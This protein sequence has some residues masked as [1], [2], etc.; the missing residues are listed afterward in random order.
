MVGVI[1]GAVSGSGFGPFDVETVVGL[2]EYGGGSGLVEGA[3]L[4]QSATAIVIGKDPA[5]GLPVTYV[6]PGLDRV[7]ALADTFDVS[8][9]LGVEYRG[10]RA[11]QEAVAAYGE[12]AAGTVAVDPETGLTTDDVAV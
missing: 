9:K 5:T 1:V 2:T 11:L 8:E 4:S 6:G 7:A 10:S 3:P 12:V